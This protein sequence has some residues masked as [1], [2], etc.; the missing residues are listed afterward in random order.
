MP[1]ER[2]TRS[3]ERCSVHPALVAVARCDGCGRRLCLACAVPV[4]GRVLG[5]ECLA[6]AL[7]DEPPPEPPADER[8]WTRTRELV[9]GI[10][11]AVASLTTAVPWSRF[12]EGA[13][14]FGAWGRPRWSMLAAS[15]AVVGLLLW[16][17]RRRLPGGAQRPWSLTLAGLGGLVALGGVLAG[18]HPPF[19]SPAWFAP[20]IAA[21]AG[22]LAAAASLPTAA[23]PPGANA[24]RS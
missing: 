23:R 12:G 3:A 4:R 15:A 20:W 9:G 6:E 11:F 5:Q 18:L 21:G 24:P 14:M 2:A 7:G 19:A 17:L 8:W 22:I 1:D 16:G 13:G 10:A